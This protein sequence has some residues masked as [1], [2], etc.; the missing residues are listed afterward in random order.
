MVHRADRK[1]NA[2]NASVCLVMYIRAVRL[3]SMSARQDKQDI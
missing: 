1:P 3:D 2:G